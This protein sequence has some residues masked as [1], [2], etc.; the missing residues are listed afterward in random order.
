M[1]KYLNRI[2]SG[3]WKKKVGRLPTATLRFK[4]GIHRSVWGTQSERVTAG[5]LV[6]KYQPG[7]DVCSIQ[8][9]LRANP[10][11]AWTQIHRPP[12]L[13]EDHKKARVEWSEKQ[14]AK[15]PK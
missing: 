8:K 2:N 4:R 9:L 3:L 13:S 6:A 5:M 15:S 11:L 1:Q 14:L 12:R 7:V 10:Q